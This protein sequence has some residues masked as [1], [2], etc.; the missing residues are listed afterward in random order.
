M[1][2]LPR[3]ALSRRLLALVRAAFVER[4][5]A[6]PSP[7]AAQLLRVL[8]AIEQ[9][10]LRLE[11][12]WSQHFSDRLSGPDG[13]ELVVEVAHDLRSPLTSILFLAE[14]LQRARSGPVNPVQERQLGLIYSAAFGLSS[15]ASDVMMLSLSLSEDGVA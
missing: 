13:L 11:A 12:D 6:L 7:D 2:A 9:V 8:S 4:A 3:N 5:S 15:V 14:T 10:G 1:A